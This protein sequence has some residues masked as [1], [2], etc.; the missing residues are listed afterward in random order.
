V[1]IG[2]GVDVDIVEVVWDGVLHPIT[3]ENVTKAII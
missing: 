2:V 1:E 3:S